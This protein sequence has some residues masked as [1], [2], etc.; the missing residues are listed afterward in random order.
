[1]ILVNLAI[2]TVWVLTRT[3]G[4]AIGG[5]GTPEAWGRTDILCA[6]LEGFAILG[7]ARRC[8][9]RGSSRRPLS[10]GV[11]FGGVAFVGIVVAAIVTLIFSPAWAKADNGIS[12]DG[13]NHG[14]SIAVERGRPPARRRERRPVAA[15]GHTHSHGATTLNGERGQG[16]EGRRTSRRSRSPTSRSTRRPAP[17]SGRS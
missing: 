8:S 12:A 4:I 7:A 14:G 9:R 1:M 16:R 10:A 15:L 2:L 11:G 5:D 3:V 13:H 17:R 6:V